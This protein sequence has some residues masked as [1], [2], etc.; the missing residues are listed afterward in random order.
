MQMEIG[1]ELYDVVIIKKKNKNTYIRVN[2]DMQI[3]VTTSIYS[4]KIF[5]KELL[6]ENENDS[7]IYMIERKKKE[8][9]KNK[10]FLILGK[11]YQMIKISTQKCVELKEPY[12]Y[13]KDEKMLEIWI[14]KIR[15]ELFQERMDFIYQKFEE[16]IP[17]PKLKI[18]SMKTRWGVCNKR[19]DS[20]T[21]NSEL[22][23]EPIECLDYV[24]IHELSHFVY[25]DHSKDFWKLVEKYNPNY[26]KIRKYLK[27]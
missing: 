26:K 19:D 9:Q 2:D 27:G 16:R 4:T 6:E 18:R 12:L 11:E 1:K 8:L 5:L 22:F 7:I 24:I 14:K 23:R 25:F 15:K 10:K 13:V 20:V 3:V 21:L 17:Y